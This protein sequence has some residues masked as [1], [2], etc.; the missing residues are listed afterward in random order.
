LFDPA[1]KLGLERHHADFGQTLALAGAP[2]GPYLVVPLLGPSSLRDGI[3][4]IVDAVFTPANYFFPLTYAQQLIV[5][6][7][8]G[9]AARDEAQERLEA[10]Q[11]SS[12]DFY[13]ALHSAYSQNRDGEIWQRRAHRTSDWQQNDVMV[14]AQVIY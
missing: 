3:G 7:G 1:S 12:V 10:L 11:E 6:G 2:S 14:G 4:E 9:L 8:R 13:A 5:G